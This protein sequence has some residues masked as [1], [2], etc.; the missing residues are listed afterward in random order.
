MQ[1]WNVLHSARWKYGMQKLRKNGHLC[2]IAPR[3]RAISLQLRHISTIGKNLLNSN[4]SSAGPHNMVNFGPLT[5]EIG[6]RVWGTP[7]NF[8]GFCVLTF[9]HRHCSTEVNQTLH[10]VWPSSGLVDYICIFGGS[11]PLTEFYLVQ[12]SL[13]VQVLRSPVLATLL[14]G[15]RAMGFSQTLQHGTRNEITELS[16][17][18][19]FDTGCHLYSEGGHHVGHSRTF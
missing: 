17:L 7:A 4:I 10:D 15:T 13:C 12:N 5:T 8:T 2:T 9:L 16:L 18:V 14:Y 11:C 19:I 3:C 1:V 6:W